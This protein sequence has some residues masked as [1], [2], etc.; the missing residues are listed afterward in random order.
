MQGNSE[1]WDYLPGGNP[2]VETAGLFKGNKM[3]V[4]EDCDSEEQYLVQIG[5]CY[6]WSA[7]H[8]G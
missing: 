5:F 3:R 2:C 8:P 1:T 6:E 4:V 7:L